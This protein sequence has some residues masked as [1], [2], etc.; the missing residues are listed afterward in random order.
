MASNEEVR[1]VM[2]ELEDAI[3]EYETQHGNNEFTEGVMA[4]VRFLTTGEIAN[5]DEFMK[6]YGLKGA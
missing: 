5:V 6:E 4:V 3:E 1:Q 2:Q